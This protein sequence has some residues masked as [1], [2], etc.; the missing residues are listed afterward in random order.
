V[1]SGAFS[2]SSFVSSFCTFNCS[3]PGK[4]SRQ[5]SGKFVS[6]LTL[7]LCVVCSSGFCFEAGLG[8]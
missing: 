6:G 7:F 4:L 8:S 1:V 2:S 3:E 5:V